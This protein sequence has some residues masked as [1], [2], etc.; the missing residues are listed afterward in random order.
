MKITLTEKESEEYFY[1]SLCNIMGYWAGYGL[2][3]YWNEKEYKIAKKK[4]PNS[5]C[6]EDVIMEILRN[7][8]TLS[9]EDVECEGEYDR[10]ITLKDIHERIA[11][12]PLKH[13][14]DMINENDD[15]D[16][17]DIILQTVF[18]EEVVFGQASLTL[19]RI[20]S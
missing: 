8:G 20:F 19:K 3:F 13:L 5:P 15:V 1:N 2:V 11:K 16:T 7:G 4:L 12:T 6:Y 10:T 14:M 18:F 9:V 17:A